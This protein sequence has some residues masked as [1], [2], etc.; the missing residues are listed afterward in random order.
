MGRLD[1][2]E[3]RSPRP[4]SSGDD[5]L[6]DAHA[7]RTTAELEAG[8]GHIRQAPTDQGRVELIVRRPAVDEREVLSEASVELD[9]GLVG[10]T[11]S[12][13]WT[14]S[15][16][17]GQPNAGKQVTLMN[18]RAAALI[19][20]SSE[21]WPLAGDQLYVDF[22]LSETVLPAGSQLAVGTAVLEVSGEPHLGCAKFAQ[23]FG[24]AALR[25]VNSRAGRELCLR[26]VNT[27]VITGGV[28]HT[29]DAIRTIRVVQPAARA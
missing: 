13:R 20:G 8:L 16:P 21:R 10:D 26:G 19:A 7:H 25:F 9:G 4:L 23:R 2:A 5:S 17:D 24:Q 18:A 15:T 11:W 29:G 12:R 22:D 1:F 6:V 14:P 27:R 28:I 3:I